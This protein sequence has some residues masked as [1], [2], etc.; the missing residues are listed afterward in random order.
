MRI[1]LGITV[2]ALFVAGLYPFNFIPNNEVSWLQGE[3]GIVFQ[4]HGEAYSTS[5]LNFFNTSDPLAPVSVEFIV[6]SF[7]GSRRSIETLFTVASSSEESF[8]LERWTE[9]LV[10]AG[11][12]QNKQ[13][14]ISFQRLFCGQVFGTRAQQFVAVTS[15]PAGVSVYVQAIEQR[16]Y[17]DLS[18]VA[19]NLRGTILIG[20]A[21]GGHQEWRGIVSGLAFSPVSLNPNEIQQRVSFW[22]HGDFYGLL[23]SDPESLIYAF[24]EGR[25]PDIHALG[26][27]GPVLR[28][29]QSL[30]ALTPAIV[31]APARRDLADWSDIA[32]NVL[33]FIPFGA[34][35]C[36]YAAL[37]GRGAG[38]RIVLFTVAVGFTISV[39]IELL[40][41]FLPSRDSS[42]L[43]V[44]MNTLGTWIGAC[45]G[46]KLWQYLFNPEHSTI[47]AR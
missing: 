8:A 23:E 28:M 39:S 21:P 11:W 14:E 34:L 36:V 16:H 18:L 19:R 30:H 38:L 45:F 40:Q 26:G 6:S 32:V 17:P 27:F 15:G 5:T 47:R 42:L 33:G 31:K 2:V 22:R 1:A 25:G 12:F 41:V 3:T 4:G 43:D 7:E 46:T 13:G 44:M 20:Q 9:D 29:P 10:V 37:G 24:Q 35:V